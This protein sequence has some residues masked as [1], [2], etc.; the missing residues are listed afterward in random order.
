MRA[1]AKR[2]ATLA[3]SSTFMAQVSASLPVEPNF[4][5][6]MK[7]TLGASGSA[8][9]AAPSVRSAAQAFDRP[10]PPCARA[11]RAPTSARPRAR[12]APGPRA[13]PGGRASAP[14]C[15][16]APSTSRSPG[17]RREVGP[18]RRVRAR[19]HLLELCL[20]R[21]ALRPGVCH[22]AA[23]TARWRRVHS[24]LL[25]PEV[26]IAVGRHWRNQHE[27][28]EPPQRPRRRRSLGGPA[29]LSGRSCPGGTPSVPAGGHPPCPAAEYASNSAAKT[30]R[31]C[32]Q[33]RWLACSVRL[34]GCKSFA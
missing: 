17:T 4:R 34:R 24:S 8:A 29:P 7:T 30:S 3:G 1:P 15:R 13:S 5:A 21:D 19:H 9:S 11:A 26:S 28:A 23:A 16:P 31:S 33:S 20:V 25:P 2:S 6:A 22:L 10:R 32:W 12:A 14:S 18:Q 27:S